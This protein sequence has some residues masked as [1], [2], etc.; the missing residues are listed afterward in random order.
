MDQVPR[1]LLP[2]Q[3][4]GADRDTSPYVELDCSAW[5]ALGELTEQPL[6]PEEIERVRG[7]GDELDL[8]E[9]EQVYLP[10]SRL[11]SLYVES[12]GQLHQAQEDFL[13]SDG[14]SAR[15]QPPRTPFL[16]GIA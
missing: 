14:S 10:L 7:L 1:S 15:P 6:S 11:L 5:A 2:S 9:V 3:Q 8:A 12:A 4:H 13:G 16:I